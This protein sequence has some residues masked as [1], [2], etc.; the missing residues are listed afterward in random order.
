MHPT[1][2]LEHYPLPPAP[3]AP[4]APHPAHTAPTAD[5]IELHDVDALVRRFAECDED[6]T[7]RAQLEEAVQR[8]E[9]ETNSS[10]GETAS[11]AFVVLQ[12]RLGRAHTRFV[13]LRMGAVG[14]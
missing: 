13:Q 3:P 12:R 14:E 11:D 6:P 8:L 5:R 9:L 2:T 7:T 1:T 4:A 10:L